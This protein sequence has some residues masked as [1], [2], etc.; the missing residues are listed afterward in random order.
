MNIRIVDA[1]KTNIS[2]SYEQGSF[3]YRV[4][5]SHMASFRAAKRYLRG[6]KSTPFSLSTHSQCKQIKESSTD[7]V[8]D[9]LRPQYIHWIFY[10]AAGNKKVKASSYHERF[11]ASKFWNRKKKCLSKYSQKKK[12]NQKVKNLWFKLLIGKLF[13]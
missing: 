13:L 3:F 5:T 1:R 8:Y 10:N 12:L 7:T 9:C 6:M 4:F 11:C 2:S